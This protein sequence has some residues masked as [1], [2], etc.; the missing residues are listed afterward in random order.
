M[1]SFEKDGEDKDEGRQEWKDM[2]KAVGGGGHFS[3]YPFGFR[4][5][6]MFVAIANSISFAPL[7]AFSRSPT[8]SKS[9]SDR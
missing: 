6:C 5:K 3:L 8:H 7:L 1:K 2:K 9:F 4:W